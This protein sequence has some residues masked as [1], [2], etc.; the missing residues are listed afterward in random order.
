MKFHRK[1][2]VLSLYSKSDAFQKDI[3]IPLRNEGS[4][5]NFIYF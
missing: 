2:V 1:S 4:T 5:K 3:E